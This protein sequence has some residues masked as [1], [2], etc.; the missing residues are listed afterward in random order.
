MKMPPAVLDLTIAPEDGRRIHLWL[1]LF[2]LWPLVL[3]L[4]VLVI[5]LTVIVDLGLLILGRTYHH[6]T[7]LVSRTLGMLGETRGMILHFNDRNATVD[8]TVR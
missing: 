2:L 8:L 5:G 6:Y 1:P 4:A 7:L 3:V